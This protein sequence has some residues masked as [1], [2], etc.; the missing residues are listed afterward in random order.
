M[1]FE[2]LVLLVC[3]CVRVCACV[4]PCVLVAGYRFQIWMF[5]ICGGRGL[6]VVDGNCER[7]MPQG[8]HSAVVAPKPFER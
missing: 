4:L 2:F 1:V 8:Q 3:V 5:V 7:A 6:V